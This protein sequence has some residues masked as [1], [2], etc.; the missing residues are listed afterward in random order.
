MNMVAIIPAR[1]GS[2]RIPRKNIKDFFG[3]PAIAYAIEV[4]R[5]SAL[6]SQIMVSTDDPVTA[7]IALKYE[8]TVPFMR[9]ETNSDD[10]ATTA[11]V[12]IEV[13][14]KC[15]TM[16][17]PITLGACIYPCAMLLRVEWLQQAATN[18]L[19]ADADSLFTVAGFS[20]PVQRA[21]AIKE[22]RLEYMYPQFQNTRSQDLPAAYMDAAQFYFFKA[23][24]LLH[25]KSLMTPNTQAYELPARE[26]QDI[27]TL[28]DWEMAKLKY[29]LR[30]DGIGAR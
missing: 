13:V 10:K 11:E 21:L 3:K 4:A 22:G 16:G 8:A 20:Y 9:S 23:S 15:A 29:Q 14:E 6:F 2:K 24:A 17:N 25:Y 1:G 5:K 19:K 18:W 30:Q 27:D 28:E 7:E 12:L 26:I